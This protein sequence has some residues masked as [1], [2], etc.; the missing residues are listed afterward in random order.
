MHIHPLI[1]G[2]CFPPCLSTRSV[3]DMMMNGDGGDG[4]YIS[5]RILIVAAS[6]RSE[7]ARLSSLV[8]GAGIDQ[9]SG[10]WLF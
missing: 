10:H 7:E 4:P 3:A 6:N 5:Q 9:D 1:H 8:V 2:S